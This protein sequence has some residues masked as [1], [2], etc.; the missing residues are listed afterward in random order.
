MQPVSVNFDIAYR[1]Y[2]GGCGFAIRI[3]ILSKAS[4]RWDGVAAGMSITAAAPIAKGTGSPWKPTP[5]L[6]P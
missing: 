4:T 6:V 2:R 5:R 1:F 3:A